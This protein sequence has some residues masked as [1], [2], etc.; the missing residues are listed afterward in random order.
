MK[1]N[2][3]DEKLIERCIL[4]QGIFFSDKDLLKKGVKGVLDIYGLQSLVTEENYHG[5]LSTLLR[6]SE[7]SIL[8][9]RADA[10]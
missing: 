3:R 8:Q 7:E 6:L 10:A 5:I 1:N 2:I 9:K 4:R